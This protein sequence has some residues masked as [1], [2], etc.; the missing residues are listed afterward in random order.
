MDDDKELKAKCADLEARYQLLLHVVFAL[1]DTVK[2]QG[3]EYAL[4][5]LSCGFTA[6]HIE[7]LDQF[8]KWASKQDEATL[9]KDDLFREYERRMPEPLQG[10]LEQLLRADVADGRRP[11]YTRLVLGEPN[12]IDGTDDDSAPSF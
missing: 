6:G 8:W 12:T 4:F 9:T 2:P 3:V 7:E 10:K 11:F 5:G 1:S